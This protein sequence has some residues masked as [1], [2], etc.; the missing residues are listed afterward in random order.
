[1]ATMFVI[2]ERDD[3]TFTIRELSPWGKKRVY[4]QGDVIGGRYW[5]EGEG[6]MTLEEAMDRIHLGE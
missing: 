1:M 2:E 6:P 5:D 3:G 4:E